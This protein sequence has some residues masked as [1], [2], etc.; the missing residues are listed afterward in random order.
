MYIY[1]CLYKYAICTYIY[2]CMIYTCYLSICSCS[3]G[4]KK[5]TSL[6]SPKPHRNY[7]SLPFFK[8]AKTVLNIL[9]ESE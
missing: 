4:Q 9:G 2:T 1:R 6:A 7:I 3:K 5:K 8:D